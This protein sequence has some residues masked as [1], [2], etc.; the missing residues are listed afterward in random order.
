MTRLVPSE[1]REI[2]LITSP[3]PEYNATGRAV[4]KITTIHKN[5]GISLLTKTYLK[6]S[7]RLSGGQ[8]AVLG[9]QYHG[10]SISGSLS[11]DY[12]NGKLT[13]PASTE[14]AASHDLHRYDKDQWGKTRTPALDYQVSADYA[15]NDKKS[16]GLSWDGKQYTNKEHR[17]GTLSY[18]VN[19]NPINSA[20]IDNHY[21][22]RIN[23]Q[24]LN[25]FCNW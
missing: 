3:G 20:T 21:R 22:N 13:Q 4:L 17:N 23:Y 15:I 24:H 6:R 10:L 8:S 2:E 18:S 14:L 5:D 7:D 25:T 1:I 12:N 19:N 11:Y 16:F 9:Y